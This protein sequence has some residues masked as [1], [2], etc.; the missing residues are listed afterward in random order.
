MKFTSLVS[1]VLVIALSAVNAEKEPAV[2]QFLPA[3]HIFPPIYIIRADLRSSR[4][5]HQIALYTKGRNWIA[6]YPEKSRGVVEYNE[7]PTGRFA[8][9]INDNDAKGGDKT[10]RIDFSRPGAEFHYEGTSVT[11]EWIEGL[12]ADAQ[13]RAIDDDD[14][15]RHGNSRFYRNQDSYFY[16]D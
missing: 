13:V 15:F 8:A 1:A 10:F 3:P 14:D 11:E 4:T 7:L 12:S 9:I 6:S 2:L 16:K 5:S